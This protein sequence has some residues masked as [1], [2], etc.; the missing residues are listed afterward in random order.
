[1]KKN[2]ATLAEQIKG[3]GITILLGERK[4]TGKTVLQQIGLFN[5]EHLRIKG[6]KNKKEDK[7]VNYSFLLN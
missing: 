5:Q 7:P 2:I 1:M 6:E 4:L 3:T